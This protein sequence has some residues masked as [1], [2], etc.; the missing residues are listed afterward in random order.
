MQFKV[1]QIQ[2]SEA[3]REMV[4]SGI[5]LRKHVL[6]SDM[7]GKDVVP[8]AT[9]AMDLGYYDHVLTINGVDLDDAFYKGNFPHDHLKDVKAHDTFSSVSVGDIIV[10]END[11]AFVVD[12]FGFEQLA[13]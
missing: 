5:E 6:K 7:F 8:N 1:L 4:N 3:E 10:D 9:K 12:T 2:L 13:A 11:Q